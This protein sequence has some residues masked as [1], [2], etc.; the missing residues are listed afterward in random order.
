MRG[1]WQPK[2]WASTGHRDQRPEG[3][4]DGISHF[5]V[6]RAHDD[7]DLHLVVVVGMHPASK[8]GHYHDR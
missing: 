2:G 8:P 3:L 7:G 5:G 6:E 4:P 1:R